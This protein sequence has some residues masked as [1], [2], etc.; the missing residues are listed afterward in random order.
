MWATEEIRELI[1][2]LASTNLESG[3][4]VGVFNLRGVT[5]RGVYD[6][7]AQEWA[8]AKRSS[9]NGRARAACSCSWPTTMSGRLGGKILRPTLARAM[10]KLDQC[11]AA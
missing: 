1:E 10:S 3:L 6:G 11:Y 5:T 7:G 9:I 8:G 2:E 4:T